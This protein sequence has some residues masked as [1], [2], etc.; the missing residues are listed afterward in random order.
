VSKKKLE[1]HKDYDG[2]RTPIRLRA[3]CGWCMGEEQD[4]EEHAKCKREV[5]W[6]ENLWICGCPCA[7]EH[8]STVAKVETNDN[9]DQAERAAGEDSSES[10][11]SS[12]EAGS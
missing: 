4:S 11:S 6:Y 1:A 8:W 9:N 7:D 10:S 5:A 2:P 12:D 3:R